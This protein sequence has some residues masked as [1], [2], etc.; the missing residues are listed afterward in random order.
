ML[1]L[2]SGGNNATSRW[3]FDSATERGVAFDVIG[4]S[5]YP[6][7]QGSLSDAEQ[8]ERSCDAL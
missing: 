1:H 8:C 4:L 6:Q 2:D 7:W 5:Y 3:R